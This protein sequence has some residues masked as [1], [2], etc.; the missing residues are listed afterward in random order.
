M[1]LQLWMIVMAVCM[2]TFGCATSGIEVSEGGPTGGS[3]NAT[4]QPSATTSATSSPAESI[5]TASAPRATPEGTND[6]P[7]SVPSSLGRI[8]FSVRN[9]LGQPLPAKVELRDSAD[10]IVDVVALPNGRDSAA[11]RAE[12]QRA[13]VYA[14]DRGIPILVGVQPVTVGGEQTS[15]V[16]V[17]VLEGSGGKRH[18][19]EFDR[20]LD[21]VLDRIETELGTNPADATSFP[22]EEAFEWASPVLGSRGQWYRGELHAHSSYGIGTE[23]VAQLVKRAESSGLDFLAITDRNTLD[24]AFDPA[25]Q[26][27]SVV[28]IPA[29]EWGDDARGVGLI[30][31]PRTFPGAASTVGEAQGTLLRVQAQGGLFYVAHPCF[32]TAP[33]QWGLSYVNGVEVWCRPW[34]EVPPLWLD[35]LGESSRARKDGQLVHSIALAAATPGLS[36]NGQA[37]LFYDHE[38]T[39]GLRAASIAGSY[40]VG[41]QVPLGEPLTYVFANEKSLKG[42]L[43]GLRW[44]RTFVSSGKSGPKVVFNGDV[45]ID[46]K[47]DAGIGGY[48]PLNVPTR[49]RVTVEDAPGMMLQ[50][51]LNGSVFLSRKIERFDADGN[52]HY[53]FDFV[54]EHYSVFR[55][56]IVRT[57]SEQGFGYVDVEALTSPIY[58]L[59]VVPHVPGADGNI[60]LEIEQNYYDPGSGDSFLPSNPDPTQIKPRWT[61]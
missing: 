34:R 8:N 44:G 6:A 9:V 24:A 5:T 36:A 53:E 7:P 28:L 40:S 41:P 12:A 4:G 2:S 17:Q 42:I 25:F 35:R 37:A 13:Y 23:S 20:D 60:W 52:F 51:L 48:V 1:K 33:W 18:L 59:E 46:G 49:F 3:G 16:E 31:G 10:R 21:L 14:Y 45:L 56:R 58:A 19:R 39:R 47:I 26:S 15:T 55:V 57:P 61:F 11:V 27:N 43:D 32:G 38:L 22:G 30:Y 54:P 50:V 29:M